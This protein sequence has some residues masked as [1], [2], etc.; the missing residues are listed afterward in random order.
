MSSYCIVIIWGSLG[1]KI[2]SKIYNMN[3]YIFIIPLIF[4]L[5]MDY[6]DFTWFLMAS[7]IVGTI[8]LVYVKMIPGMIINFIASFFWCLYYYSIKEIPAMTLLGVFTFIYGFGSVKHVRIRISK[9]RDQIIPSEDII[10][11]YQV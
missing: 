11:E 4:S 8:L 2:Y 5:K 10:E 3:L 7:S 1:E 9:T 6:Y